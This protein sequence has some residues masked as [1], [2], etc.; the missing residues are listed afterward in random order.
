MGDI[1]TALRAARDRLATLPQADPALEADLLLA[2]VLGKSRTYLAAWPERLLD[3]RELEEFRQLLRRRL[4]GEPVAYILGH[5]EFWSLDL[6]VT[7]DVL[8]PRPDTELLVE[9]AL[10]SFSPAP[11]IVAA[12]LGTGSGAIAAALAR[13]RPLWRIIATDRSTPA[14]RVAQENL[15]RLGLNNVETRAGDWLHA[16]DRDEKP[17]LIVS[18]PPYVE[19]GDPHL[20]EGDPRFEPRS[21]LAAGSDGLDDIRRI[22]HQ[23]PGY[24]PSGGMLLLE[25]GWQQG[26]AVRHLLRAAGFTGVRTHRDLGGRDRVSGGRLKVDR[27]RSK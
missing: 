4:N 15:R 8:I 1:R 6:R 20:A 17:Q 23:A 14:L 21:A 5:R 26:K 27:S 10:Q 24:L 16:L 25:H 3:D 22:A 2:R 12:D 18:N 7:P 9:L 19:D 11:P 13:E